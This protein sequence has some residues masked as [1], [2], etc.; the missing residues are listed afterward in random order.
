MNLANKVAV[1][2]GGA[3]GLGAATAERLLSGGAKV[4]ILDRNADLGRALADHHR[5]KALFIQTDVASAESAEAAFEK[6]AGEFGRV[7]ICVGCAGIGGFTPTL[8]DGAP[9]PLSDFETILDV[10]LVGTFN[11]ARLAAAAMA[12][13][14]P[15][16]DTGERGVIVLTASIAGL[17][18]QAGMVSYSVSKAGIIGMILPLTR[19]LSPLGIRVMGIAPGLYDTPLTA[20]M[21]QPFR[22]YLISTLEFP[23]R[24]GQPPEFSALVAHIIDN[25]YLNGEVIRIDAGTRAPPR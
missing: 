17:E 15:D 12:K 25:G 10:N 21:P 20:D 19:D 22:D 3:S 16:T 1:V 23:K 7:D 24:G 8:T 13:N 2:S 18:G 14:E 5:G 11:I 6:V 9:L 4:A